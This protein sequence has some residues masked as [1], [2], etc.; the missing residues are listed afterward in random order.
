MKKKTTYIW[1]GTIVTLTA[2]LFTV[3][4]FFHLQDNAIKVAS[5]VKGGPP[6]L[7]YFIQ[8]DLSTPLEKPMDVSKIGQFLYVTDTNHKQI[9]V[10]D[11]SGT[12]IFK[13]GKQGTGQGEFQFPYGIDGDKKG[14]VYV[15]DLYNGKISIFTSK[16]KFIKY[17]T[18]ESTKADF[19]KSPGG[20]RI[21]KNSLY[22]TDIQSNRVMKYDLNSGKKLMDLTSATSKDDILN[23]PNAVTIDSENNIYVSDTGNQRLVIYD[24]SGKF[25]R[26]INGST[27]GK[28]D[29]K[30]VNPRG[31][32]VKSDGTLL[33]VDNMTHFV[34][35][36]DKNGKQV[37]QFGGLGSDKEQFYLPNGLFVD[38][39]GEVFITDTVNQRIALYY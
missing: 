15:A 26:I 11:T 25:L 18:D 2:V 9:Q 14:N 27:D 4:Y 28:G 5:T 32:G 3:I 34:Y 24:K 17:F 23:A 10:F 6:A 31:I 20:L 8:G 7:G 1:M 12:P 13:F 36:F 33:M 37:F 29:S 38:D 16:G 35:G 30:F 39:K 21:Y 22:V 19:L